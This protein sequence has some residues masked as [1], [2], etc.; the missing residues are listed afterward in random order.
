MVISHFD[1]SLFNTELSITDYSVVV[2]NLSEH[3]ISLHVEAAIHQDTES[4]DGVNVCEVDIHLNL[5]R[6][7]RHWDDTT[8]LERLASDVHKVRKCPPH[9]PCRNGEVSFTSS[10]LCHLEGTTDTTIGFVDF[11]S[12]TTSGTLQG[13]W[14]PIHIDQEYIEIRLFVG[15]V[16]S[17]V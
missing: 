14:R 17:D 12:G 13:F 5:Q 16:E 10:F 6:T 15:D 3:E 11:D 8:S 9:G 2:R 4:W 7:I 1:L